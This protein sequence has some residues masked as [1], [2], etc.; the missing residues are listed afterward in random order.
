[1][2]II[3]II[4]HVNFTILVNGID[5]IDTDKQKITLGIA[6]TLRWQDTRISCRKCATIEEVTST[7]TK[8]NLF[9]FSFRC[10]RVLWIGTQYGNL[11]P[12]QL[13]HPKYT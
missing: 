12:I 8:E 2:I 13:G 3:S 4:R 6:M 5:D 10:L 7:R 11:G 9:E 1:M